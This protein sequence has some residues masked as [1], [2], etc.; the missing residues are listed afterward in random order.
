VVV[1]VVVVVVC[2]NRSD[3]KSWRGGVELL[4]DQSVRGKE[5]RREGR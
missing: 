4:R 3:G 2:F 5:G 1:V